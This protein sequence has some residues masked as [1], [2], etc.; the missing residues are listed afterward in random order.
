[1]LEFRVLGNSVLQPAV[2]ETA[3]YPHLG[4][5]RT[6]ADVEAARADLESA[7]RA[8]GFGTVFVDIPEQTVQSDGVVRLRVTEGRVRQ[9][10]VQGARYFSGRQIRAAI[11]EAEAGNVPAL[12][13][14]QEE[15]YAVNA[16]SPDRSITPVLK[17]GPRP[18]TMDLTL[19]V[20][21]A[22]PFHGSVEVNN[23]Y[24]AGT[25]TLRALAV[26]SYDDLFGRL[27]SLALQYQVAP[28]EPRQVGVIAASYL[29][30]VDENNSHLSL[31]YVHSSSD[32]AAVG[33]LDIIGKGSIYGLHYIRPLVV[34]AGQQSQLSFGLD[35][36]DFG[37]DVRLD[38]D[39]TLSTP[40]Q[41]ASLALAY[42]AT[43]RQPGRVWTA[44]TSIATGLLGLGS[45]RRKFA[46]KCFGCRPGFLVLRADGTVRQ[47]LH[48]G[49]F[50]LLDLGGQYTPDPVISNE[51]LSI[52]GTRSIRGYLEA[53][54]LGDI[55]LRGDVELHAPNYLP[56][57]TRITVSPYTFYA[58]GVT[59]YQRPLPGQDRSQT[60]RSWGLGLNLGG[61]GFVSGSLSWAYP[62]V[63]GPATAR[64][65]AR[66]EFA[67]RSSW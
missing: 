50:G 29:A 15:I 4:P 27:D 6:F 33:A 52:G 5:D 14:L 16:A 35:Y 56:A 32:L 7:Y 43:W 54:S 2:I 47:D 36:K 24:T 44:S 1:M 62:L 45:A 23:Q 38:E 12:P 9:T 13:K 64:G 41:Y 37:Q 10:H 28:Q 40:L 39:N 31:S 8:R 66:W 48:A 49:F 65:D 18:G 58:A 46:D 61:F 11:P 19:D 22:L 42:D 53:E 57:A 21:D 59:S 67:L 20:Q 34:T 63:D 17:A 51:Q 3:V 30:R 25:S 26:A 55:G 60:L